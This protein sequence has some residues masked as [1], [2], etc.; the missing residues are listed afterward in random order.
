MKRIHVKALALLLAII[1]VLGVAP[2]G[3]F[4]DAIVSALNAE[5][6]G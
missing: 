6:E 1:M 2:L 4:A 3:V 5:K